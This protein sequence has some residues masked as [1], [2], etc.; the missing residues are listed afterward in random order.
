[1]ARGIVVS[2]SNNSKINRY[3]LN[4]GALVFACFLDARGCVK[5]LRNSNAAFLLYGHS[6]VY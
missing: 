1:M 6:D 3:V 4:G 2:R 5:I